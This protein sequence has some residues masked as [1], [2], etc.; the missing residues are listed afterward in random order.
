MLCSVKKHWNLRGSTQI[1]TIPG[2]TLNL[3]FLQ[4][5]HAGRAIGS[6]D[7]KGKLLLH[8]SGNL[9]Q[10][11][12]IFHSGWKNTLEDSF[13]HR[14][15]RAHGIALRAFPVEQPQD[16]REPRNMWM[17]T[18]YLDNLETNLLCL[19]SLVSFFFREPIKTSEEV[20]K[21]QDI[22]NLF[23]LSWAVLLSKLS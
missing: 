19:L 9:L 7:A 16:R 4:L 12:F 10:R 6:L 15:N 23:E 14:T 8:W 22:T 11:K 13:Q 5:C 17:R 1:T 2:R 20:R 18:C 21:E 3:S